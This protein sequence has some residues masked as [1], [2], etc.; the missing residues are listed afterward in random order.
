MNILVLGGAG[1]IGSHTAKA[2]AAHG[3][4]PIVLDNL[5]T[6]HAGLVK[7]GPLIRGDIGD[8][9]VLRHV[10][11]DHQVDGIIHFAA[12]AYVGE[13]MNH[14][15]RYF[16]NNV[17]NSLALMEEVL[18]AGIRNLVFSSSCA[19]YGIP[20]VLPI[21]ELQPQCPVN[22]YGDS[23]LFI[24]RA[25]RAFETAYG[26]KWVALRYFNAAGADP[27]NEIGERHDPETHLIPLA[28]ETALGH[29]TVLD[30]YGGDYA[31]KDGTPVRDFIHVSDLAVAHVRALEY[32]ID[33]GRSVALNLGTGRGY[34]VREIVATVEQVGGRPVPVRMMARRPGDPS[35]LVADA[36]LAATTLRWTPVHS[37]LEEIVGTAWAWHN[38]NE[39][40]APPDTYLDVASGAL[41]P[42]G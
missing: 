4:T 3:M 28:I 24:E 33:G 37:T 12:S 8:R 6:G 25:L 42:H 35:A 14:P 31:T 13:S 2:L 41:T 23:K 36:T 5:S 19:T 34:T 9:A 17:V 20:S 1:Y 40:P 26:L 15:R 38:R 16:Q 21:T 22:P 27:A 18:D 10:L 7:W 39:D 30:V 32:L 11:R 29:R